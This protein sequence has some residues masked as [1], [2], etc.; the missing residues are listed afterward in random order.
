MSDFDKLQ[1]IQNITEANLYPNLIRQLDKDFSDVGLS[2]CFSDEILP[3]ELRTHLSTLV[4]EIMQ[5][6]STAYTNLLYRIDVSEMALKKATHSDIIIMS[7][8]VALLI[9]KRE[10]QKVWLRANF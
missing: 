4:L 9:L 10:C 1:I 8:R 7:E 3:Q 2:N 5:H 6:Q